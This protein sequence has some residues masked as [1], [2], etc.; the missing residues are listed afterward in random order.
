MTSDSGHAMVLLTATLTT[1]ATEKQ[2]KIDGFVQ[3]ED[4]LQ[5]RYKFVEN[6]LQQT[7]K[8]TTDHGS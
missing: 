4:L 3:F 7:W 6:K 1:Q 5:Y 2:Y 8:W